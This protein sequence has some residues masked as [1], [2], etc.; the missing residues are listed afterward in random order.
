MS[1]LLRNIARKK[2]VNFLEVLKARRLVSLRQTFI[3]GDVLRVSSNLPAFI[4]P[5]TRESHPTQRR[6]FPYTLLAVLGKAAATSEK[7]LCPHHPS[8]RASLLLLLRLLRTRQSVAQVVASR[9][10]RKELLIKWH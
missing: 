6:N 7:T 2:I 9:K 4:D 10:Q 3:K 8:V 1:S 5:H